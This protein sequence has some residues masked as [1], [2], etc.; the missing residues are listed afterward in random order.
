MPR[1]RQPWPAGARS[2]LLALLAWA[3]T[4]PPLHALELNQASEAELDGLRGMGP[5]LTAQVLH[6]RGDKPFAH[7]A[8]F[9]ARVPGVGAAKMRAFARQ[10]LTVN[11]LTLENAARP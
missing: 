10:G 7:W 1:R 8:D 4:S 9:Q 5:A 6:A 11:G 3:L 2:G